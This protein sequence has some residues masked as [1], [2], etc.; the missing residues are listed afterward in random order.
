MTDGNRKGVGTR[1]VRGAD[2]TGLAVECEK[3]SARRLFA[4]VPNSRLNSWESWFFFNL[5]KN[6]QPAEENSVNGKMM[7][8][9]E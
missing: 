5:Q 1:G 4:K 2:P 9:H 6:K 8:D 3:D 7:N